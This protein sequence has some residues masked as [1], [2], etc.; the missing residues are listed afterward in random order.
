M[1]SRHR[2]PDDTPAESV[3]RHAETERATTGVRMTNGT[4]SN[5]FPRRR[6][7]LVTSATIAPAPTNRDDLQSKLLRIR[8]LF[9]DTNLI[10][11]NDDSFR[12]VSFFPSLEDFS[13]W[14]RLTTQF[15]TTRVPISRNAP[16]SLN[17]SRCSD[18]VARSPSVLI[19]VVVFRF[20][21]GLS[22]IYIGV[23]SRGENSAAD[24]LPRPLENKGRRRRREG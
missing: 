19:V 6:Y 24:R 20:D 4:G 7:S 21:A 18:I 10:G 2:F 23:I 16:P 17:N 15:S 13:S 22:S 11:N 8:P 3:C 9:V 5:T 14:N 1:T 12:S